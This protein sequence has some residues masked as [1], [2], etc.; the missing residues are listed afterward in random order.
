MVIRSYTPTRPILPTE[1]DGTFQLVVKTYFPSDAQPG[2]AISNILDCMPLEEEVEIR[3]PTGDIVYEGNGKFNIEGEE[4]SFRRVTLILGGSGITPG[5]Q[6]IC[7]ILMLEGDKTEIRVIDANRS[8]SDILLQDEMEDLQKKHPGQ[9]L[10]THVL[11]R[12]SGDWKGLKGYA[13]A[14]I[15]REH[16][17]APTEGSVVLLC[18]PPAMIQKAALPALK[19]MPLS[20]ACSRNRF[21]QI[22]LQTGGMRRRKIA[23]ASKV[24]L[25]KHRTRISR[26]Y[27]KDAASSIYSVCF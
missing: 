18:G 23:L 19:G 17:F 9:F 6:L 15:I 22:V 12:P 3:G 5:Y 1:E 24:C 20:L 25:L 27:S 21:S 11:S 8:E 13:N 2:G 16:A 10:I 26:F 14:D 7:R 4:M